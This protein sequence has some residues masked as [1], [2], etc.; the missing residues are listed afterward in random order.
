MRGF[1]SQR[2]RIEVRAKSQ[3]HAVVFACRMIQFA[4]SLT[5]PSPAGRGNLFH[6]LNHPQAPF[7][8]DAACVAS[9]P[10]GRGLRRGR[11]AG[12]CS[13]VRMPHD[14]VRALP[15]PA[16]SR[17]ERGKDPPSWARWAFRFGGRPKRGAALVHGGLPA[18]AFLEIQ[19]KAEHQA[20]VVGLGDIAVLIGFGRGD[21]VPG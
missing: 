20:G 5:L 1:L 3:P 19:S 16:L 21:A 17:W 15:H 4:L 14:S 13:C 12:R 18:G 9:S 7:R 11:K 8:R 6:A 2:E 10:S